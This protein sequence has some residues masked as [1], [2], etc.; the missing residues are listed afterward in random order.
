MSFIREWLPIT[1]RNRVALALAALALPLFVVWNCLPVYFLHDEPSV[2][3]AAAV[4]W[5]EVI[6]PDSYTYALRNREINDF[7]G[8]AANL[9]LLQ[10]GVLT[11]LA[12]PFWKLLHA[13]PFIRLPLA[14]V[15]LL[16]GAIVL[17]FIFDHH[18]EDPPPY[19]VAILLLIGLNMF[20]ISAALLTFRNELALREERS[21]SQGRFT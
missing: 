15:D 17:W 12:V 16:G 14:C 3:I 21:R 8:I 7:L 13:S 5:Q 6:S 9:A 1:A 18:M 19:M 20:A 11:L 10:C 2:G 4:V